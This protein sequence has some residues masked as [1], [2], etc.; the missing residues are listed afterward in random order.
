MVNEFTFLSPR[1]DLF[2]EVI[3]LA[4][5]SYSISNCQNSSIAAF[6]FFFLLEDENTVDGLL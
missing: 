3:E 1:S 5:C 6:F 4:E 2:L